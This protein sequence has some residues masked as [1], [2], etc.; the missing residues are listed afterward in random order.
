MTVPLQHTL[1]VPS[2]PSTSRAESDGAAAEVARRVLIQQ[3]PQADV[4]DQDGPSG[5]GARAVVALVASASEGAAELPATAQGAGVPDVW[6][7]QLEVARALVLQQGRPPRRPHC[8]VVAGERLAV[9]AAVQ[10]PLVAPP[11]GRLG[12]VLVTE[13]ADT[14]D[15]FPSL[16]LPSQSQS[17]FLQ[18]TRRLPGS[19]R[20]VLFCCALRR[21]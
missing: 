8:A 18:L 17:S 7:H 4:A 9:V 2:S 13:T 20:S 3:G 16:P 15:S 19:S 6:P 12:E 21:Q 1:E 14:H 11:V 5:G 10:R